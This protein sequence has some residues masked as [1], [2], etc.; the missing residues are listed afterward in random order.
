M[1]PG[2]I[3]KLLGPDDG[4]DPSNAPLRPDLAAS[5]V[6]RMTG[7]LRPVHPLP[8]AGR[9]TAGFA[10]I[11]AA[12]LLLAA[13]VL[14][15]LGFAR[16]NWSAIIVTFGS[17]AVCIGLVSFALAGEMAPGSR[18]FMPSWALVAAV[19]LGLAV[20]SAAL[21]PYH[22]EVAFWRH[23]GRCFP[24]GMACGAVAGGIVWILVC[25]GAVMHARAAG[26][27]AGLLGGVT[28]MAVLEAH[29]ANFNA[30]HILMAHWGVAAAGAAAG[31]IGAAIAARFRPC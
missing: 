21:F 26:A 14:G 20:L 29:C 24:I 9:I 7:D 17:L 1:K 12:I 4:R 6:G 8:S 27:L 31:W 18:R 28:G 16:L 23:V 11:S 19:L 22:A 10:F 13:L 25:R 15:H 30:A 5:I 3:D 2:D